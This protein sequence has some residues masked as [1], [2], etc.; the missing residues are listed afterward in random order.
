MACDVPRSHCF[1]ISAAAVSCIGFNPLSNV[2]SSA[3][4]G[5][6]FQPF[7]RL[8]HS[9]HQYPKPLRP[10][11]YPLDSTPRATRPHPLLPPRYYRHN[12]RINHLQL[13]S[14]FETSQSMMRHPDYVAFSFLAAVAVSLPVPWHW[15][16]K[17][18]ATLS[19]IFWLLSANLVIFVNAIIWADNYD[20]LS[21]LWCDICEC[22]CAIP[23]V[24]VWC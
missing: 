9:L 14:R 3:E 10:L 22:S 24:S 23:G 2:S 19:I 21:P 6:P 17:N 16:A 15:R 8:S 12:A 18:I 13:D 11:D 20:D 1:S 7:R 5:S 4:Y